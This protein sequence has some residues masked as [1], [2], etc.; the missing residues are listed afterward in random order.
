MPAIILVAFILNLIWENAHAQLYIGYQGFLSFFL[1]GFRSTFGDVLI[2]LF[3]YYLFSSLTHDPFWFR[4]NIFKMWCLLAGI[5]IAIFIEIN[6]ISIGRWAYTSYMPLIPFI[7]VGISPVL[8]MMIL[9][10]L[11]FSIVDRMIKKN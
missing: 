11:T 3:L 6:A 9:P 10:L 7:N 4:K 8:Q 1:I 5:L 2:I